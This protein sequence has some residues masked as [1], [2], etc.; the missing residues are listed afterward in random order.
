MSMR[1]NLAKRLSPLDPP[2]V[3]SLPNIALED[4]LPEPVGFNPVETPNQH[5]VGLIEGPR[6]V[7]LSCTP[8]E[9]A[10]Q[11]SVA[12]MEESR[13]VEFANYLGVANI[14][15]ANDVIGEIFSTPE[16]E[17]LFEPLTRPTIA[18][19][20]YFELDEPSEHNERQSELNIRM[21]VRCRHGL[22]QAYCQTCREQR[23]A[24]S[25][26]TRGT[27][28]ATFDV[29]AQLYYILQPPI[30][31]PAGQVTIFPNNER[32]F[33]FQ[34]AGV[35]WLVDKTEALLADEMGLGKTIQAIIA[36]RVLFRRG[37]LQRV[38]VVCPAS[39]TI[40]WERELRSWSPELRPIR[41]T[42]SRDVRVEAWKVPSEVHIVSYETLTRD[43]ADLPV[44]QFDLCVLDEVQKIKNPSS[45]NHRAV[46][47]LTSKRRWG[48]SGTPMENRVEDALA[49]LRILA[50]TLFSANELLD[51]ATVRSRIAPYTLRRTI[52]ANPEIDL[53]ALNRRK[54]QWLE[55]TDGQRARYER[56][57]EDGKADIKTRGSAATRINV[58]ALIS[59]LKQI[60]NYDEESGESCKLD[61]LR[62]R[63]E[64]IVANHDKALVFSQYPVKTLRMIAAELQDFRPLTFDGSL[65]ARG[66]D[67]VVRKFQDD[68]D[69]QILL[70]SIRAGGTGLTL[71]RANHVF[72]FDHWWNPAVV[73][74]GTGRVYRIGQKRPVFVHSL[75]T[76]DT[77]EERIASILEKKRHLFDSVFG[78]L[79][80][81]QATKPLTDE[82]LFGLFGLTPPEKEVAR[83]SPTPSPPSPSGSTRPRKDADKKFLDMTP[84]EFEEAV[85]TLFGTLGFNLAVTQRTRDGGI[86]L[87]GH[88]QGLGGGRVIVQCKRYTGTVG[89]SAVRDLFGVVSAD[90]NITQGFL[91]TTGTFSREARDFSRGKR[92]TLIDGVELEARR[93]NINSAD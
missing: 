55:L 89:V 59:Q 13:Q 90:N 38:L 16:I 54:P 82:D 28:V 63:L 27:E 39:L 25:R 71:T 84:E 29:F 69:H 41:I 64:E 43:I 78:D 60:C 1:F 77:V 66:R 10:T 45:K 92:L 47:R 58:L 88:S 7:E 80:D 9:P 79:S 76:V 6:Q 4:T 2:N 50:P 3:V 22:I 93:S 26:R 33:R 15:D 8:V 18:G 48:L 57:E 53:P 35:D 87:D 74:Q 34:I 73:D 40:N 72:H 61:F 20:R 12:L 14:E 36:M 56:A 37:E 67:D 32:P 49:V 17:A 11:H 68:E 85:R 44:D 19:R 83:K 81:E 42:G 51:T 30:L 21:E 70:I 62:D 24:S 91:V 52:E 23:S 5:S 31:K 46:R 86:D 75:Y 65:S